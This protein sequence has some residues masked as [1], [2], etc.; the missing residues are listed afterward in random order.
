[1]SCARELRGVCVAGKELGSRTTRV[2][3]KQVRFW[4]KSKLG[5]FVAKFAKLGP[6][7]GSSV[8]LHPCIDHPMFLTS[9]EHS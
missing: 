6:T 8:L 3:F 9:A 7:P 2:G 1:M 4:E 5:V